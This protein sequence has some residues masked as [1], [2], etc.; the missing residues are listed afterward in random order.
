M[1]KRIFKLSAAII[2][3]LS[4]AMGLV[5][6]S[7]GS[8]S[9]PD[10]DSANGS[11][12]G[13]DIIWSYDADEKLL[14]LS[15]DGA[16][17]DC[18]SS[19]DVWWYDVRHSVE[20]LEISGGI[21]EIGSYAFY[22]FAE[23][24]T[25]TI[26]EGVTKLGDFAFAF[27][28][29]LT[30][31]SLPSTLTAVGNGCFE[32]CSSLEGI[33]LSASVT[34]IG[35]RAFANCSS[36]KDA[37]IMA[38]ISSIEPMTFMGCSAL[39]ELYFHDSVKGIEPAADAFEGASINKDSATFLAESSGEVTLTVKYVYEDGSE[40][41]ES[42]VLKLQRGD[43]YSEISPSIDGFTA[44]K[45][46]VSGV[47]SGDA[48][49][50]VT[51]IAAAT[52]TE[53]VTEPAEEETEEAPAKEKEPVNVGTIITIVIFGIVIGAIIV[54]AVILMRSDKKTNKGNNSNKRK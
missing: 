50:V 7:G 45:L 30:S 25:A 10:A 18:A 28:S 51:Y 8:N 48:E 3:V 52:E 5:S 17:P 26:P 35:E 39:E 15:G 33:S 4:L 27:S 13:T 22:Y 16:L 31:V 1:K 36:L 20:K 11:V 12:D 2:L 40:A 42:R 24:K 32:A 37:F 6:C 23:L 53:A 49:E 9:L 54:L 46:S 21:T 43:S 19:E 47:I 29:S 44:N 34:S 41:A 38:Q 14:K